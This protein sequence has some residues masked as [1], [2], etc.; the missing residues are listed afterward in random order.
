[1]NKRK[2][3]NTA[4]ITAAV[5]ASLL[6]ICTNTDWFSAEHEHV[7]LERCY[8]IVRAG[9]NDCATSKHS[10]AS[11]AIK[12]MTQKSLSCCLEGC[13][14]ESLEVRVLKYDQLPA[15]VKNEIQAQQYQ[16]ELLVGGVQLSVVVL[17]MAINCLTPVGYTQMLPY[18]PLH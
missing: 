15:R 11:Q 13:V 10:C 5:S 3:Q 8:E 14:S 17:L 9:K 7:E 6:S 16:S 18:I 4:V 12:I 2:L 1:M